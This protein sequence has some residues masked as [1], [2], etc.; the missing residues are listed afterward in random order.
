MI[1]RGEDMYVDKILNIFEA[2][3]FSV[4]LSPVE[5]H[6]PIIFHKKYDFMQLLINR[7]IFVYIKI[8]LVDFFHQPYKF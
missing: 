5:L 7:K 8:G 2:F 6:L 3:H 1:K 4:G